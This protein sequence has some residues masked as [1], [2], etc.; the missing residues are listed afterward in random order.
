MI[1]ILV[2]TLNLLHII[3][4][5]YPPN[6]IT[7]SCYDYKLY[8]P[9]ARGNAIFTLEAL[10]QRIGLQTGD[11]LTVMINKS[12]RELGVTRHNTG[13]PRVMQAYVNVVA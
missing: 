2:S 1:S 11:V 13:L 12:T 4:E 3:T 5:R 10:S 6:N 9:M 8:R 7:R